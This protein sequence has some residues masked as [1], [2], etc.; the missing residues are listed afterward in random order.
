MKVTVAPALEPLSRVKPGT[1]SPLRVGLVQ[2]RWHEDAAEH[3]RVLHE[4]V[5]AATTAGAK[6]VFLQELTLSRYPADVKPTGTPNA[7][8]E[9]VLDGATVRFAREAAAANNV[10]VHASLFEYDNLP[11][12]RGWNTA[13]VVSPQGEVVAKTRKL[14]IP[15]TAGYYE[16][17]YFTP[18]S[19]RGTAENSDPYPVH[20]FAGI[21]ARFGLP[22]CWDEWFPEVARN[23]SLRGA[24]ILVYPTAIGSEPD[25]PQFD[26]EPLWR[27][28]IVGNAIANGTFMVV[29]NRY[30]NEGA[31]NFYGSSFICDP[32]G[33]IMVRAEREGDE[34]LIA[35]LDLDQRRDWLDL[36]PF[37]ATRRP[38]TYD[39][40][41][42]PVVNP[43]TDIGEG[44]DGGIA[45]VNY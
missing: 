31:L 29:P 11:D 34:V 36:F 1:R 40:L 23:Y 4:G 41:T 45:G 6:I 19:A 33:R 35:D 27:Q 30:G 10:F 18:G 7:T 38:D 9:S 28:V 43:R 26:T 3:E 25:H 39:L 32:Y 17:Q 12:G 37:L 20:I 21:E 16:D 42:K 15:V 44:V 5:A 8:A 14:H 2:T 22:T 13:I 24:E